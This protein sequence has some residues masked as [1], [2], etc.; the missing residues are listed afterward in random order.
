M[1]QGGKI[2]GGSG[3]YGD[4]FPDENFSLLHSG[5][6]VV[7]MA[8]KGPDSNNMQFFITFD[9]AEWL[10]RQHV[11]FGQVALDNHNLSLSLSL[12]LCLSLCMYVCMYIPLLF[13][14]LIALDN[15]NDPLR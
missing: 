12:S 10:D 2:H 15:P 5:P 1:A 3:I 14:S 6:G 8:N 4:K 9:K 13:L 7:S 11:A